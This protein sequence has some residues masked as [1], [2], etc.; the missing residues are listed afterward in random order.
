[1]TVIDELYK[2]VQETTCEDCGH[3][4]CELIIHGSWGLFVCEKCGFENQ[5][6]DLE[7]PNEAEIYY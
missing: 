7:S 6:I 4:G 5:C 3:E 2:E 1:M